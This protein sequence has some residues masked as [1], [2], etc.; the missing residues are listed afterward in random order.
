VGDSTVVKNIQI[1]IDVVGLE[2]T[3]G[4][5]VRIIAMT[6]IIK[7]QSILKGNR[8]VIL[9]VVFRLLVQHVI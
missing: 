6:R 7:Q 2:I 5:M 8:A 9:E 4:M 1:T 3:K